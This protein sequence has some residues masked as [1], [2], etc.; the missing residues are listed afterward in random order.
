[1]LRSALRAAGADLAHVNTMDIDTE[2][3][4]CALAE[5]PDGG[6]RGFTVGDGDWPLRGVILRAGDSVRAYLN[7]CP[8][9][10]HPLNLRPH[11]FLSPDGALL[12]CAS[13]GALFEKD[14]GLCIAGPCAG[15]SLKPVPLRIEQG[16]ALLDDSV[17]VAQL[18][19]SIDR[20]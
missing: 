14:Q 3:V 1:M 11:G 19:A 20:D 17:D 2:R 13:H 10:G 15:K 9:A 7:W 12:L 16:Y 4:I 5:L 6:C 8:H 18:A